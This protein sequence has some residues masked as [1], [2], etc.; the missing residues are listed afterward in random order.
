MLGGHLRDDSSIIKSKSRLTSF[1][2]QVFNNSP[3]PFL[4]ASQVDYYKARILTES[5]FQMFSRLMCEYLCDMYSRCEEERLQYIRINRTDPE[6]HDENDLDY[7][8]H[9]ALPRTFYGSK[10]WSAEKCADCHAL[11]KEFG[12]G[13]LFIT[14]TA[15]PAWP[16]ISAKLAAGERAENRPDI[17]VRVFKQKLK[18]LVRRLQLTFP[19]ILNTQTTTFGVTGLRVELT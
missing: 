17:T 3:P 2:L 1:K 7:M 11:A 10:A 16:K 8:D 6:N 14:M 5:R 4:R 9:R 13:S 18:Q 12:I 15:N 19:N